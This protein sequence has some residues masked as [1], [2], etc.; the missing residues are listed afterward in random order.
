MDLERV[1]DEACKMEHVISPEVEARLDEV[2]KHPDTCPHGH[3]IPKPD[4]SF[5][6]EDAETLAA[7]PARTPARVTA[8]PE[9]RTDLL[10][11]VLAAEIGLGTEV[12]VEATATPRGPVIVR[13]RDR[14]RTISRDAAEQIRVR[15][16]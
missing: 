4:G 15:R 14:H 9:E 16:L 1:Y 8:I 13:L 11:T 7:L 3:A 5:P 12:S 10:K 2:L 6:R